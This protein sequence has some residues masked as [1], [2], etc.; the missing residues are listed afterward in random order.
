MMSDSEDA[1]TGGGP[2]KGKT[3]TLEESQMNKLAQ[4]VA[5]QLTRSIQPAKDSVDSGGPSGELASW[6][7]GLHV[8]REPVVLRGG[9]S[10]RPSGRE[11]GIAQV[12]V[13]QGWVLVVG[14]GQSR[15]CSI[16]WVGLR[17]GSR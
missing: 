9:E 8:G 14:R 2:G 5:A 13:L 17:Q 3:I 15:Q 6:G 10:V 4:L 16:G 12:A 7:L 11:V 1:P